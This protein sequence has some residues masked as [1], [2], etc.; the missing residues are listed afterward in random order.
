VEAIGYIGGKEAARHS[1]SSYGA[2]AQIRIVPDHKYAP[3]RANNNDFIFVDADILDADGHHVYNY[4]DNVTFEVTGGSIIGPVAPT[5]IAGK[6]TIL[7]KAASDVNIT[8]SSGAL[9]ASLVIH[10]E[11]S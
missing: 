6:A 3:L 1:V 8:A 11:K 2:P 9:T 5:A 10:T 7:L 4:T